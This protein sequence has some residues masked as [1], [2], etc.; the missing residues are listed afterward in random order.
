MN[1]KPRIAID[2]TPLTN[3]FR[4]R[5]V[6]NQVY[7][8]LRN[9]LQNKSYQWVFIA[10]GSKTDLVTAL[11]YPATTE[12]PNDFEFISLGQQ[13]SFW[14]NA[15][16]WGYYKFVLGPAVNKANADLFLTFQLNRGFPLEIP[17]LV[18]IP[19]IT[20]YRS[21]VYSQKSGL[22]NWLKKQSYL[23]LF[24]R[25]KRAARILSPSEF[26]KEDLVSAGFAAEKITVIPLALSDAYAQAVASFTGK[27]D[28]P[29]IKRRTLNIYNITEPYI[30]YFGGLETN[31]NVPQLLA[32]FAKLTNKFPDL[33]LVIG[34][35]EFKLGWDHKA[36]PL[37]ERAQ[38]IADL[39]REL[40]VSHKVI[41][42]G[43][44]ET[45][46]LPII[47][48]QAKAFVHLS[49]YE[50]FGLNV[51]EPQAVGIPVVAA[52]ASTYPEVL[53]DSALLVDP[54]N[55]KEIAAAIE[56]LVANDQ[57]ARTKREDLVA[58]GY[59]NLDRFSWGKSSKLLLQE[60][61]TALQNSQPVAQS[62]PQAAPSEAAE[63][64]AAT[65][66]QPEP[67]APKKAVVIS[68]YFHP[69]LGGSEKV[70]LDY[71]KFLARS[72]FEVT[73]LTSDRK[74]DKV[75]IKKEDTEQGLLIKRLPRK[76]SNYYFYSLEGLYAQLSAIQPDLIHMHGFGFW[77]HDM[78]VMRYKLKNWLLRK[79]GRRS[80]DTKVVNTPHGPFMSKPETGLRAIFK[81]V[82][83][84]WQS[85]YLNRML[86]AAIAVNPEQ[87][88]WINRTY[89]IHKSK[90]Q[91]FPPVMPNLAKGFDELLKK[92]RSK[93]YIQ[94]ASVS[95]LASY[96]GFEDIV[97]AFEQINSAVQTKL[98]I[99][100]ATD[101]YALELKRIIGNSTRREDIS[102]EVDIS[103]KRRDEILKES[104]IFV[105]ASSWEAFGIV[106]GEAMA[107]GNALVSSNTEGGRFLVKPGVN[108]ELFNYKDLKALIE[109]L[110]LLVTDRERI[111]N[112]QAESGKIVSRFSSKKLSE[113]YLAYINKITHDN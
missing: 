112:Y 85:L 27:L 39:A 10:P 103:E 25:A 107:W 86:T 22:A 53:G 87:T 110:N 77:A 41:F 81:A 63:T 19:D 46:H 76:G 47:Y 30:C 1:P 66:L 102:F 16:A 71:A 59:K 99:A 40:K 73:V 31:K 8:T 3:E 80:K 48:R 94:I 79:F 54:D 92:K 6:G 44:V 89:K 34:G 33:K 18:Y 35:G 38:G 55:T 100:G 95:R 101:D 21:G 60:I 24:N 61:R 97:A 56:S 13:N 68:A 65:Q 5:G 69:F 50:G 20:P 111:G 36:V 23:W 28:D 93:R 37:N 4:L 91:L 104:D 75:V 106:L 17:S 43:F 90:I 78:A 51:L 12:L 14:Q 7:S 72:G 98:V 29:Q 9:L 82:F 45:K 113:Q 88:N 62:V 84:F 52:N 58:A 32:S 67:K 83:T 11:G 64:A 57:A 2:A 96:K 26:T 74:Q 105:F 109:K 42:T 49:K 70:A 15:F 108:G